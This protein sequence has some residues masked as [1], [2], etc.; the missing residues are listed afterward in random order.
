MNAFMTRNPK[1]IEAHKLP[2]KESDAQYYAK[3]IE[4]SKELVKAIIVSGKLHGPMTEAEQV[5][6]VAWAYDVKITV[7]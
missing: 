3:L 4:G 6:L 5:D 1:R 7:V 2:S